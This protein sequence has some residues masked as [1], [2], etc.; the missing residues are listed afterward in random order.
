MLINI[1][2]LTRGMQKTFMFLLNILVRETVL[3]LSFWHFMILNYFLWLLDTVNN[4]WLRNIV[5]PLNRLWNLCLSSVRV[6]S[7]CN[8]ISMVRIARPS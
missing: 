8:N 3:T 7:C 2:M 1:I 6:I 5:T 4:L